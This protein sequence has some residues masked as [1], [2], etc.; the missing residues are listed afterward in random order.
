MSTP[1]NFLN[2]GT[3]NFATAGN[4]SAGVPNANND[5]EIGLSATT[6]VDMSSL[7]DVNSIGIGSNDDLEINDT[8]FLVHNGTGTNAIDG[9]INVNNGSTLNFKGAGV[10]NSG[11][12]NLNSTGSATE[13]QI[14]NQTSGN[15]TITGGGSALSAR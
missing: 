10:A 6:T 5:A 9:V 8:T 15:T 1:D 2:S 13:I 4:W 3:Q 7:E 11:D 14:S 12:I